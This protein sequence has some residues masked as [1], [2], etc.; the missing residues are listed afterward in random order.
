MR[1]VF[2]FSFLFLPVI[3]KGQLYDRRTNN[4]LN[5][6][7]STA[8]KAIW[9]LYDSL[10]QGEK[11]TDFAFKYS[12]DPGSYKQGGEL[13][14]TTMQEYVK[15]YKEVVFNLNPSEISKPF[16]SD[17]GYHIVQLVSR[18]DSVFVTRH[19]LLRIDH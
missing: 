3:T 13:K 18:K 6:N 2:L 12:Q 1:F 11:F 5:Y 17:F 14:S 10:Q 16:R 9:L 19:V 15:E 4:N 7:D 8:K